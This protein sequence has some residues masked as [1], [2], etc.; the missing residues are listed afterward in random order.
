METTKLHHNHAK[1]SVTYNQTTLKFDWR[2][3]LINVGMSY[4]IFKDNI[5]V[6]LLGTLNVIMLNYFS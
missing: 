3:Y 2:S 1:N 6:Y 5:T 4:T